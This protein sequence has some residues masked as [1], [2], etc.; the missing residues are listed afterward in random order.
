MSEI[1]VKLHMSM[2]KAPTVF[3]RD[4][5]LYMRHGERFSKVGIVTTADGPGDNRSAYVNF[6]DWVRLMP[7]AN[8]ELHPELINQRHA[9]YMS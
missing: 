3:F 9:L 7:G 6:F 5:E 8:T 2:H 1:K 4:L